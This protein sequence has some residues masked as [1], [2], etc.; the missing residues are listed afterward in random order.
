MKI[1]YFTPYSLNKNLG[2]AYNE[3]M[4]L[5]P[6]DD[7]YACFIDADA[8]FLNP[9]FGTQIN[10]II[11]NNPNVGM[12]TAVTNRVGNPRQCYKNK[13][14]KDANI[15]HHKDISSLLCKKSPYRLSKIDYPISGHLMIIQKKVWNHF[16]FNEDLKILGVDN[17]ISNRLL[18][19]GYKIYLMQGVYLFHYYRLNEGGHS[20][21]N[22]LL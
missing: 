12:F 6:C 5:L 4:R 11:T 7:D 3:Y 22:H 14:S 16:H 17:D 21:K 18:N 1:Y 20:F 15:I 19:A 9:L 13:I 8:M 10:T 2:A